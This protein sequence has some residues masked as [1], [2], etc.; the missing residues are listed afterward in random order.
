MDAFPKELVDLWDIACP[1]CH[2]ELLNKNG[3]YKGRQRFLCLECGKTFTSY[4][5]SLIN[6]SKIDRNVLNDVITMIIRGYQL[7][8]I[9]IKTGISSVSLS[10]IRLKILRIFYS[11]N[12]FKE[13]VYNDSRLHPLKIYIKNLCANRYVLSLQTRKSH[14]TSLHLNYETLLDLMNNQISLNISFIKEDSIEDIEVVRYHESLRKFLSD[15]RG[16]KEKYLN[17]YIN[18]HAIR[19][20]YSITEAKNY[21]KSRMAVCSNQ[22]ETHPKKS[23]DAQI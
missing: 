22:I 14:F 6:A 13:H 17:L 1:Y 10:K 4:S 8:T 2:S 16:I 12:T 9:E 3:K 11:L 23:F 20:N 19:Y 5:K 7:K 21:L 15:C 18:F